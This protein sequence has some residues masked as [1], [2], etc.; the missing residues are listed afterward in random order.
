MNFKNLDIEFDKDIIIV[1]DLHGTW[2][3]INSLIA[4]RRPSTVLQCG[5]FGWWPKFHNTTHVSSGNYKLNLDHELLSNPWTRATRVE[6]PWNQN[7]LKPGPSKFYFCPGNHEDWEELN[8]LATSDDPTP[9]EV[10]PNVHFMPRCSTLVLPDGRT[11]LFIGGADSTDK[12]YRKYRYDWYPEEIITYR[13]IENLPDIDIDI[14]ISHTSPQDFKSDLNADSKDWRCK[15]SYWL[16]KFRDPTCYA[17]N[18][19]LEKYKPELWFFGHYHICK[20]ST[21]RK[22]RWFALNKEASIGWW[23]YLPKKGTD[24]CLI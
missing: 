3:K 5:D 21:W 17:L 1:G 13:D 7:G 24:L 2:R 14:I 6:L 11:V 12:E 9:I 16:E 18:R 8:L 19:V 10:I 15:D 20:T 23:T 4:S 22:T